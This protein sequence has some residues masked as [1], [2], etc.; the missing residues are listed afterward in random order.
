[1]S[2]KQSICPKLISSLLHLLLYSLHW[3]V[4]WMSFQ[5]PKSEIWELK[6]MR[7]GKMESEKVS[8]K[9][10]KILFY[11]WIKKMPSNWKGQPSSCHNKRK[12]IYASCDFFGRKVQDKEKSLNISR[13]KYQL[14]RMEQDLSH[15]FSFSST[16][17]CAKC[18]WYHEFIVQSRKS[19][20]GPIDPSL[21]W[22]IQTMT[23]LGT[24]G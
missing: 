3:W 23:I 13:R 2:H 22:Q 19:H 12:K 14:P 18:Y 10:G 8:K 6:K 4:A 1:M 16:T 7:M 9:L 11:S 20:L 15:H 5:S 17:S 21:G 24:L